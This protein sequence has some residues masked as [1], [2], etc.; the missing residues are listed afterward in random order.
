ML[1]IMGNI[2][3]QVNDKADSMQMQGKTSTVSKDLLDVMA[4]QKIAREKETAIKELQMAQ[5]QNPNTIKDQLEQK[6]MGMTQ[7]EMTN[8]TAGILAQRAQQQ[9]KPQQRRPQQGG[10]AGARPPMGGAP[11]PPMGGAPRP[12]MGGAPRPPM[13]GA[14][15][16]P[17]GGLPSMGGA[18]PPM[19]ASGGIVA[20]QEGGSTSQKQR[21]M[22]ELKELRARRDKESMM[23]KASNVILQKINQ[24]EAELKAITDAEAA[25]AQETKAPPSKEKGGSED[26][27]AQILAG[28]AG[29]TAESPIMDTAAMLKEVDTSGALT[30]EQ[31]TAIKPQMASDAV[32]KETMS[33]LQGMAKKDVYGEG[34][35][36]DVAQQR[37]DTRYGI[38]DLD[39]G[40]DPKTGE[41]GLKGLQDDLAKEQNRQMSPE[42]QRAQMLQDM[43]AGSGLGRRIADAS[44][45]Q[46]EKTLE[47]KQDK[48]DQ[49]KSRFDTK[50]SALEK[51]D[52]QVAKAVEL[53]QN[54]KVAALQSL[55]NLGGKNAELAL[56][57][58]QMYLEQNANRI[59]SKLKA[60]GISE[61]TNLRIQ[62]AKEGSKE[63][64]LGLLTRLDEVRAEEKRLYLKDKQVEL[65][66]LDRSTMDGQI[67]YDQI[68]A[69]ANNYAASVGEPARKLLLS[70]L[71]KL[72]GVDLDDSTF[73][74]DASNKS[75]IIPSGSLTEKGQSLVDRFKDK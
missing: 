44:R 69:E 1:G 21:L 65:D 24:K 60:I 72:E 56:G 57:Q 18:R 40:Q 23:S 43:R 38:A 36:Q 67:R 16:P 13:G 71:G 10:I 14:P 61:Q 32:D 15:R 6:V 33:T 46:N 59:A 48:I 31:Q 27:M 7:G 37:F 12:P 51:S 4:T 75:D 68:I 29:N 3:Q 28:M 5:Q 66:N 45:S 20:F 74:E 63:K 47:F 22:N 52:A 64:I 34:G 39:K 11:R 50:L 55:A 17:M 2:D 35:V 54:T 8:Q 42:V 62:L 73:N 30:P 49:Y 70:S 9:G 26:M 58:T 41:M 25:A 19:M 53:S